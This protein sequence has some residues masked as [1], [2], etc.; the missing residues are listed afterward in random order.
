MNT[1]TGI[2]VL[3]GLVDA[4]NRHDLDD[5]VGTFADDVRS[6]TPAH[7]A[8]SFVGSGQVRGNWTQILGAIGDL[9][10]TIL[11]S[12]TGPG[13]LAGGETVWAELAF[14]AT[15]RTGRHGKCAASP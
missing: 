1:A 11:A 2:E 13:E 12:A 8:R 3:A 7:P 15:G 14:T 5:L 4:V 6:D 10:A 9:R